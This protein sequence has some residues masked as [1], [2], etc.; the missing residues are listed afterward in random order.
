M[1]KLMIAVAIV[2]ATAFVQAASVSWNSG[3]LMT[4][5]NATGGWSSTTIRGNYAGS[6]EAGWA[7][8]VT[9]YL[10]DK[11]TYDGL[12]GKTQAEVLAATAGKTGKTESAASG[13]KTTL[14]VVTDA[15]VGVSQYAILVYNYTDKTLGKDFYMAGTATIAGSAIQGSDVKYPVDGIAT[16]IADWQTVPEPTSGLLLLLGVAGLALRRRRA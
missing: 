10:I 6:T 14:S 4:A 16:G 13:T 7:L 3:S 9:A 5:A 11:T 12:D 2:C 1:K 8:S 15:A